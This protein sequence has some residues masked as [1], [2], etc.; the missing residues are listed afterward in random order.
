RQPAEG[1]EARLQAG[2]P[3]PIAETLCGMVLGLTMMVTLGRARL[4]PMIPGLT[5]HEMD[6]ILKRAAAAGACARIT[7]P[8]ACRTR[9][10]TSR[11]WLKSERPDAVLKVVSSVCRTHGAATMIPRSAT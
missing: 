10:R 9:S 4:S 5:D 1:G 8:F 3:M 6:A 2:S 7:A 11:E